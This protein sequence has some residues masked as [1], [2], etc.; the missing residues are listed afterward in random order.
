M[1]ENL[2]Y[3]YIYLIENQIN[4]K[5]YVGQTVRYPKKRWWEHINTPDKS[6]AIDHAIQK[7]G[8]HN[9]TFTIIDSAKDLETLNA[10]E[11]SYICLFNSKKNINGYNIRYGGSNGRLSLETRQKLIKNHKGFLGRNHSEETKQKI[12]KIKKGVLKSK[13]HRQKL[14]ESHKGKKLSKETCLKIS[15]ANKGENHPMF[16]KHH[17]EESK[18]K[19]REAHLGENNHWYGKNGKNHPKYK[20]LNDN[21][22]I[23]LYS[24][25]L[26]TRKIAKIINC[27]SN[28]VSRHLKNN[29]VIVMMPY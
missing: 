14:S 28:T 3:G 21:K 25:G 16:G 29:G 27:S 15:E 2:I 24:R 13:E 17:S 4:G 12:S 11:E 22:M 6:S 7:Y 5:R 10:L 9:F 20:K 23:A 1:D 19:N 18:Q 8:S 26:S